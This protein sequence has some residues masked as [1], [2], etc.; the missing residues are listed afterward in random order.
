MVRVSLGNSNLLGIG[1]FMGLVESVSCFSLYWKKLDNQLGVL[2][3]SRGNIKSTI[4][5]VTK[6]WRLGLFYDRGDS[7]IVVC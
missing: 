1:C 3:D 7:A 4:S 6:H 5:V 2:P